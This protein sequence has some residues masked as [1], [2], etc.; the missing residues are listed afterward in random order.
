M[1]RKLSITTEDI[2]AALNEYYPGATEVTT[3]DVKTW[4][5][6][7]GHTPSTILNRLKSYK[8]KRGTYTLREKGTHSC[9]LVSQ[10]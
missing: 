3:H 10:W 6:L 1:P 2:I 8:V 9:C 5:L 7:E 4:A